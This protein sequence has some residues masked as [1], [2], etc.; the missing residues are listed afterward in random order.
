MYELNDLKVL[1][2]SK[3][4]IIVIET[5]EEARVLKLFMQLVNELP[6]QLYKWAITEGLQRIDVEN[7][8]P[9]A[10]NKEP[11]EALKHIRGGSQSGIYLFMDFHPYMED[12]FNVRTI[13]EIALQYEEKPNTLVFVSHDR[14]FVSS[15]ANCIVEIKDQQMHLFSGNYEQY[16]TD[17]IQEEQIANS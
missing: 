4:P 10:F 3:T 17:Q 14:E 12:P 16:L 8:Q 5:H 2:K 1:I 6:N 15:L 11:L 13:K 7:M 9:Q